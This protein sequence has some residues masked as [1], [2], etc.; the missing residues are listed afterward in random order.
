MKT[1]KPGMSDAAVKA[2]TGKDWGE[3]FAILDEAGAQQMDHKAIVAYLTEQH[4]V[5]DWWRQS[6]TVAYEQ[7]RGLRDKHQMPDGYQVSRS[8]TF[9]V[10]VDQVYQAWEDEALRLQWL[11]ERGLRLRSARP[12]K[13][14]RITWV[15][16]RS[17]LDVSFNAKGSEKTQVTVQHN[18]LKDAD[19]AQAMKEFWGTALARLSDWLAAI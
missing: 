19:E 1:V 15:D 14:L 10:G 2:K 5:G 17:S 7:A 11:P 16:G 9:G 3:W 4:Q 13:T 6:V 12:G 18:K 8:K